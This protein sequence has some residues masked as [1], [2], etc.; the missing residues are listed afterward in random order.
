MGARHGNWPL[1]HLV[2][3]RSC[4]APYSLSF[5]PRA[6]NALKLTGRACA[7][8]LIPALILAGCGRNPGAVASRNS[9]NFASAPA[10][11]QAAWEKACVAAKTNGF[12]TALLS[13]ATIQSDPS[14]TAD[15]AAAIRELS[16]SLSDKMYEAANSG[17]ANAKACLEELRK[18]WGR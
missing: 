13:L 16:K 4:A 1:N 15:Q 12:S 18:A 10:A 11:T 6:I 5:S 14:L 9:K 17:D 3:K 7:W 2:R 8:V